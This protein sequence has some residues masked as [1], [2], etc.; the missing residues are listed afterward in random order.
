VE[1]VCFG[2][3]IFLALS[4]GP[5]HRRPARRRPQP[6]VRR[7]AAAAESVDDQSGD[8]PQHQQR[9]ELPVLR[10]T[11]QSPRPPTP[12]QIG[13]NG[14]RQRLARFRAGQ[15]GAAVEPA[16]DL[17]RTAD[18]V[19]RPIGKGT[20]CTKLS[21]RPS[22]CFGRGELRPDYLT[23]AWNRVRGNKG[24]RTAGVDRVSPATIAEDNRVG[25]FLG[26]V[27]E[28]LRTRTFAPLPVRERLIPKPNSSKL[29]RLGIPTAMDR[30]VQ[31]SLLLVLEPIFEADFKPV[32]YGFR[33]GR[34]AQGAIAEV[35]GHGVRCIRAGQ[36]SAGP[37]RRC[38]RPQATATT[39]R[40]APAASAHP[41][42][43]CRNVTPSRTATTG[44]T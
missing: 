15:V 37:G 32:S 21:T 24:A 30:V 38:S 19:P 26:Q 8:P 3:G 31:A 18:R 13:Q 36:S 44:L 22:T 17:P 7:R 29:R 6:A 35:R 39:M 11:P 1:L 43:S 5:P 20:W 40:A 28:L 14:A 41:R 12:V 33:P 42:L 27:R 34:W 10:H 9:R 2:E 25:E 16:T 4:G 23:V